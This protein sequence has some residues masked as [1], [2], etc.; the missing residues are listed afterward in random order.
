MRRGDRIVYTGVVALFIASLALSFSL[1]F[2]V[3]PSPGAFYEVFSDG[4][5]VR[6]GKLPG[7][8]DGAFEMTIE[9]GGGYNVLSVAPDGIVIVSADCR[10]GDCLRFPRTSRPGGTIV[11]LPHKLV[12]RITGHPD[13]EPGGASLDAVAY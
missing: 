10:A 6:A 5:R 8:P 9:Y 4:V 11:C 13:G 1:F 12:V 2:P 3:G 7:S